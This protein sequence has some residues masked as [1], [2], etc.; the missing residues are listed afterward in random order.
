MGFEDTHDQ[1]ALG[2]KGEEQVKNMKLQAEEIIEFYV[3]HIN[4]FSEI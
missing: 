1:I 2:G 4:H 3:S